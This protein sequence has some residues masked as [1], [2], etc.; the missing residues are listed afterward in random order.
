MTGWVVQFSLGLW[1]SDGT[2][3]EGGSLGWALL[4]AM[5]GGDECRRV[6]QTPKARDLL[7]DSKS[8]PC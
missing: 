7:L 8:S 5:L 3:L 4:S 1:D 2:E 6:G